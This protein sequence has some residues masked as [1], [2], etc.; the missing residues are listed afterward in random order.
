LNDLNNRVHEILHEN[1]ADKL[2]GTEK[3]Q[4]QECRISTLEESVKSLQEQGK[5]SPAFE[6]LT[7]GKLS[8]PEQ[9]ISDIIDGI[10]KTKKVHGKNK[11]G[12][13]SSLSD[14]DDTLASETFSPATK[15]VGNGHIDCED[16][17]NVEEL[18]NTLNALQ[19]LANRT[20]LMI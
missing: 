12:Y 10:P 11:N 16:I 19:Q 13:R 3:D 7:N 20:T 1:E 15:G 17:P 8:A 4:E 6:E 5:V 14:L 2:N 9:E 18:V